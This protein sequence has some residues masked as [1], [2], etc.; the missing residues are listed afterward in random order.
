MGVVVTY[1]YSGFQ[2]QFPTLANVPSGTVQTYW[3]M[4]GGFHANDG[5]GPVCDPVQQALLMNFM[6]AHLLVIFGAVTLAADGVTINYG[7][8]GRVSNASEGSV[9]V[10]TENDYPPGSA[11]WYQ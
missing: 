7:V 2:A 11:Q 6:A 8:V 1:S 5:Q 9:S 10:T 4:A 3:N